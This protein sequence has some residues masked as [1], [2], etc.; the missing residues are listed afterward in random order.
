MSLR[1]ERIDSFAGGLNLVD[2]PMDVKPNELTIHGA[3][4]RVPYNVEPVGEGNTLKQ[5]SGARG[6]TIGTFVNAVPSATLEA[7][8]I[9]QLCRIH[10][11]AGDWIAYTTDS[12]EVGIYYRE[13]GAYKHVTSVTAAAGTAAWDFEV[14]TNS[15]NNQILWMVNGVDT[16][17][18]VSL[19]AAAPVAPATWLG[20]PPN[21]K[22]LKVWKNRMIIGGVAAQPQRLYF[23]D[24]NNPDSWPVNNFIDIRSTDDEDDAVVALEVVGEDLLV[25]K[26]N[27]TWKVFDSTTFSNVRLF[28]FGTLNRYTTGT[29]RERAYWVASTGV[30]STD[31]QDVRLESRKIDRIFN[32]TNFDLDGV[33]RNDEFDHVAF[34]VMTDGRMALTGGVTPWVL[35]GH[36]D[37]KD[38]EGPA[39]FIHTYYS[40]S[41]DGNTGMPENEF[42]EVDGGFMSGLCEAY[43]PQ[44]IGSGTVNELQLCSVAKTGGATQFLTTLNNQHAE[45]YHDGRDS[46]NL[47]VMYPIHSLAV[48]K[49]VQRGDVEKPFRMRRV[50]VRHDW[51]N[52]RLRVFDNNGD[53]VF[54]QT[55][56]DAADEIQVSEFKPEARGQYFYLAISGNSTELVY[57]ETWRIWDITWKT[58]GGADK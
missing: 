42:G 34:Q 27:S 40:V 51:H 4:R 39:W 1:L 50:F 29:W 57:G 46:T 25:F 15:A 55:I 8:W 41:L 44:G 35:I 18:A 21:G 7:D 33:L 23:S 14:A 43:I 54:D 9:R 3:F 30:Y 13:A 32:D 24:I 20:S 5:R 52:F 58:R 36:Q 28:D 45:I 17:K 19:A 31:G 37:L 10:K 48:F 6:V 11:D 38:R 49:P 2:D 22:V 47:A 16:P 56:T 26:E 12:G 53:E